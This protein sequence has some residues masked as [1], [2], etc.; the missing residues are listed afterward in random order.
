[1]HFTMQI[2]IYNKNTKNKQFKSHSSYWKSHNVATSKNSDQ[3]LPF[4]KGTYRLLPQEVLLSGEGISK[5]GK[6]DQMSLFSM[7]KL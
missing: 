3:E 2:L 1:M 4:Y 5:P 6:E 7:S